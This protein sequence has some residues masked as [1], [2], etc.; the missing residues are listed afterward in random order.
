MIIAVFEKFLWSGPNDGI[1]SCGCRSVCDVV[2]GLNS[3][4]GRSFGSVLNVERHSRGPVRI[5]M[6][7][8]IKDS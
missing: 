7:T 5:F 8:M 3:W 1:G 2:S 4:L 6:Q